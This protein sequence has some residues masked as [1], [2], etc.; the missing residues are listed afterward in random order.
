MCDHMCAQHHVNASV[1]WDHL[2]AV[3]E[4]DLCVNH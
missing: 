4:L 1:G 3:T 2:I